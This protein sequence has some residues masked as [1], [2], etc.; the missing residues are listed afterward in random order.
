MRLR[1]DVALPILFDLK[2]A[3]LAQPL[4]G[5]RWGPTEHLLQEYGGAFGAL[6]LGIG[7]THRT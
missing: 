3:G 2:K 7:Q 6:A 1:E 5:G 4:D